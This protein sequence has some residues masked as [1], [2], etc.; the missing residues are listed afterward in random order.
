MYLWS[1]DGSAIRDRALGS[2]DFYL[3][4]QRELVWFVITTQDIKFDFDFALMMYMHI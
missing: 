3:E 2:M 4:P 1:E